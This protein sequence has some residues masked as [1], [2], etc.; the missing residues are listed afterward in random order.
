MGLNPS[1]MFLNKITPTV[2]HRCATWFVN[3]Q[4][5]RIF[6]NKIIK[7]KFGFKSGG[8]G[9]VTG[10]WRILHNKELHDFYASSN[11]TWVVK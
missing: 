4:R 1:A 5:L 10:D 2:L 7:K 3:E 6:N 11:F 9:S 8:L